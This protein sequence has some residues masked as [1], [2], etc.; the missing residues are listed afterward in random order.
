MCIFYLA[1]KGY[2][3]IEDPR[4]RNLGVLQSLQPHNIQ[5]N[6]YFFKILLQQL[7]AGKSF[8]IRQKS[9]TKQHV[10]A[11]ITDIL[12]TYKCMQPKRSPKMQ[13]IEL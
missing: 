12:T 4:C 9:R 2:S 13:H 11:V 6:D 3:S 1:E 8:S 5:T 10:L 7:W